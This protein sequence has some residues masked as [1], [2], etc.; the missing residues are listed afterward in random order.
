MSWVTPPTPVGRGAVS[1]NGV[2]V[3]AAWKM[4]FNEPGAIEVFIRDRLCGGVTHYAGARPGFAHRKGRVSG[5]GWH[6]LAPRTLPRVPH[7]VLVEHHFR[8]ALIRLND[9][10]AAQPGHAAAVFS[11]LRAIVMGVRPDALVKA[12]EEFTAWLRGNRS[13]PL[14]EGGEH[15][16]IRLIDFSDLARNQYVVTTKFMYRAGASE[17]RADLVLLV[18]GIPL[19][20]I[21]TKTTAGA[22]RSW[23]DGA[24]Q[25]HNYDERS[26]PELFVPNL[27]SIV[28]DNEELR[29]GS[30]GLPV[31]MWGTW[32]TEAGSETPA[33]QRMGRAIESMLRP[34]VVLDL[35][36]N[37]TAYATDENVG[38]I[39]IV[40]RHQQY[41]AT[42]AIVEPV[43]A[44]LP[45]ESVISL[46]DPSG[47]PPVMLFAARKL[48][49]HPQLKNPRVVMVID[50]ID[51][52]GFSSVFNGAVTPRLVRADSRVELQGVLA[53]DIPMVVITT[54]LTFAEAGGVLNDRTN[55]I[56]IVDEA[57]RMHGGGLGR[58]IREALPNAFL[59]RLT[60][61]VSNRVDRNTLDMFS[62][63]DDQAGY[64]NRLGLEG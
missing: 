11:R 10:I 16:A 27:V 43:V 22:A 50:P 35:L 48:A 53:E 46:A 4:T 51:L 54:T 24:R 63:E 29:Y 12:N 38:A 60:G 7:E 57:Q 13:M 58:K 9:E 37:F 20:V 8:E 33:T 28:F 3:A 59:F 45:R 31:E 49:V 55:T 41:E 47:A 17:K 26:V 56:V 23:F 18:N 61:G 6:F 39:K 32:C 1:G 30:I 52:D 64:I 2:S 14:E 44:G 25:I 21:E 40:A 19:V 36:A 15:V 34:D 42:N 62:A 5:L